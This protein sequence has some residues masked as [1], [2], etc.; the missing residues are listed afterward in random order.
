MLI[1][2]ITGGWKELDVGVI[3]GVGVGVEA[4]A[5]QDSPEA[6]IWTRRCISSME[7]FPAMKSRRAAV[8]SER[9]RTS[10]SLESYRSARSSACAKLANKPIMRSMVMTTLRTNSLRMGSPLV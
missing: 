10:L 5:A 6:Y 3:V 4:A 1:W 7:R 9:S 2:V 8:S